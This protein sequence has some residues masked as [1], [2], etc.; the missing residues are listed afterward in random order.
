MPLATW[1]LVIVAMAAIV[2]QVRETSRRRSA[3]ALTVA[4]SL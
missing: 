3:E 2:Y 1:A 4:A